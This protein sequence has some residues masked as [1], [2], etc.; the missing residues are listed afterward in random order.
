MKMAKRII[1]AALCAAL[2]ITSMAACSKKPASSSAET[3]SNKPVLKVGMECAY[4][5]YN[6]TQ[7]NDQNGAVPISGSSE[8]AYGYDVIVAKAIA[9]KIGYDLEIVKT[10]WD[11][12]PP[13]VISGKIDVAIAGMSITADRLKSVDFTDVYYNADILALTTK[14]SP[15]ASATSLE[16]LKGAVCT[17]QLNTVWYDL[18]PQIPEAKIQPALENVPAMIVA[19]T[20]GKIQLVCTDRP[21]AM[22]AAYSNPELVML[23]FAAEKGFQA[24]PEDI[25]IGIAISKQNTELK[26]KINEA[27]ASISEDDRTKMMEDAIKAQPLAQ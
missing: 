25:K 14:S 9:E 20:S 26:A 17:S 3:S 12:L 22:A 23:D 21:T 19:L 11:G 10:E 6:W 5:P 8:Y 16:D 7:S 18:L 2:L 24:D 1:A 27:L 15:F 13:A 4:A